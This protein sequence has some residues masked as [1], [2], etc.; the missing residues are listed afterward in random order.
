MFGNFNRAPKPAPSSEKSHPGKTDEDALELLREKV[1]AVVAQDPSFSALTE[2]DV[3]MVV[4]ALAVMQEKTGEPYTI[5]SL[6]DF[7]EGLPEEIGATII[8]RLSAKGGAPATVTDSQGVVHR[9]EGTA[10][11]QHF[12]EEQRNQES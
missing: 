8:E 11:A 2:E 5:Q 3:N 12:V 1:D 10:D 6:T 7:D 9:V 4:N